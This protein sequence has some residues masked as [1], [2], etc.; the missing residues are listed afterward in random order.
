M[1]LRSLIFP[2]LIKLTKGS[3]INSLYSVQDQI[4]KEE[5]DRLGELIELKD[6]RLLCRMRKNI[7]QEGNNHRF[8]LVDEN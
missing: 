2:S 8:L 4:S 6:G 7:C 5:V 1:S 3:V